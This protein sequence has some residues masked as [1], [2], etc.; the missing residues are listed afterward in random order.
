MAPGP[1]GADDSSLL[2]RATQG[3][4]ARNHGPCPPSPATPILRPPKSAGACRPVGLELRLL[5]RVR[6]RSAYRCDF[7]AFRWVGGR[8]RAEPFTASRAGVK[9]VSDLTGL[10]WVC[11]GALGPGEGTNLG[12]N[13]I[14]LDRSREKVLNC[15]R[16]HAGGRDAYG[17]EAEPGHSSEKHC[18]HKP[19]RKIHGSQSPLERILY[20]LS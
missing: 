15:K 19:L 16:A 6:P 3:L 13:L 11:V 1:S 12:P 4:A 10:R 2:L 8:E 17:I 7:D 5:S 18:R 20:T 9:R 14:I